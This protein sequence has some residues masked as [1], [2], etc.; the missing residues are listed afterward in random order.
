MSMNPGA[1][2]CPVASSVRVPS[3]PSP[4]S[5]IR[6]PVMATS[7]RRPGAPEPST[8]VPPRMIRSALMVSAL[9]TCQVCRG[10]GVVGQVDQP[11]GPIRHRLVAEQAGP[12]AVLVPVLRRVEPHLAAARR[13][14]EQEVDAF[15]CLAGRVR[16]VD[17]AH[18]VATAAALG[19]GGGIAL[20]VPGG[21]M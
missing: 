19:A 1:T 2:T 5:V 20:G 8:T 15:G 11:A 17:G 4:S 13:L 18:V 10:S 21:E 9:S 6:S 16:E 7:A 12:E 14:D 3:M